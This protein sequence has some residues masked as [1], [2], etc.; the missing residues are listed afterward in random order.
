VNPVLW[1][2]LAASLALVFPARVLCRRLGTYLGRERPN[3]AGAII[4]ASSG[5]THLLVCPIAYAVLS[6]LPPA[7]PQTHHTV[8]LLLVACAF[9]LLG[10]IDDLWGSRAVGG[11]K[12]HIR[13][14]LTGKPTTG[15][16]KLGGG[17]VIALWL[18]VWH[19]GFTPFALVDA[20]LI[21]LAANALNLLDVRP[22]RAQ[23]GFAVLTLPALSVGGLPA[24]FVAFP[25]LASTASEWQADRQARAMMGD[26]GSNLLGACAGVLGCAFLPPAGRGLVLALLIALNLLSERV[27]LSALIERTPALRALDRRL[28]VRD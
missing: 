6:Q 26:T 28:G 3:F 4:P 10:L 13:A 20:A 24:L 7:F 21:A 23:F 18:G 11:F 14:L 16:A 17:G 25:L 15:S 9:G 19:N 5:L 8:T 27:S 2:W 12:G 22:G 1:L